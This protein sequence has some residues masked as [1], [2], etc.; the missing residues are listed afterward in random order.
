MMITL[1]LTFEFKAPR[2]K[3]WN[4]LTDPSMIK[5]YMF[6]TNTKTDWKVGSPITFSGMWDGKPYEDKGTILAIEPGVFLKYNYFSAFSGEA[7]VPGSYSNISY[8]LRED[9]GKTTFTLTQD[10]YKSEELRAHSEKNWSQI[11]EVMRSLVETDK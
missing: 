2:G 1:T 5:K 10:N 7:D 9:N 11:I 8:R 3:V 6:D 4:A